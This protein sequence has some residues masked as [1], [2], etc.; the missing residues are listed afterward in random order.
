MET[1]TA[2]AKEQ[3]KAQTGLRGHAVLMVGLLAIQY[4]LGMI[5][6]L[7]VAF[8]ETDQ[9]NQLWDYARTQLPTLAHIVVGTLLL[10]SAIVYLIRAAGKSNRPWLGSAVVGALGILI[11][12]FGGVTFT[13]TQADTYSLIMALGFIIGLVG[14]VWGLVVARR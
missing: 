1:T 6:N 4:A 11:A 14:Y 12:Y 5:T 8:P 2:I 13:S 7:Y 10:L 3:T 9:A